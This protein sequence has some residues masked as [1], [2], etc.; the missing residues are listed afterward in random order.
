MEVQYALLVNLDR[1]V[2]CHACEIACKQENSVPL[3]TI[4][5]RVVQIGPKK[6]DGKLRMD[7]VPLMSDECTLCRHRIEKGMEPACVINC[8]T[9][10]LKFC[11]TAETLRLLNSKRYQVCKVLNVHMKRP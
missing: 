2:G 7:F 1:C 8:P 9:Q 10:A 6:V 3:G 11:D 4:W 5:L